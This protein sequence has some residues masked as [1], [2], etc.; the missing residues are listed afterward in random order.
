[1]DIIEKQGK[2]IAQKTPFIRLQYHFPPPFVAIRRFRDPKVIP[3][4]NNKYGTSAPVEDP[5]VEGAESIMT[6]LRRDKKGSVTQ[7]RLQ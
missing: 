5:L 4:I 3:I 1:M 7:T 6:R 2:I